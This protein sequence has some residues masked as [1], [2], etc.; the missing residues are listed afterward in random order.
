MLKRRS[1]LTAGFPSLMSIAWPSIVEAEGASLL[2]TELAAGS[3][4]NAVHW[5]VMHDEIIADAKFK[6]LEDFEAG[7]VA[8]DA[9]R[10]AEC[11]ICGLQFSIAVGSHAHEAIVTSLII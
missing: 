8:S 11:P 1:F 5:Q 9:R 4:P 3:E 7:R 6:L 2:E 10:G